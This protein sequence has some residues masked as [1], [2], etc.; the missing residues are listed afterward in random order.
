ME[1]EKTC[2]IGASFYVLYRGGDDS[3][4]RI[5]RLA[6]GE[7][8]MPPS[9]DRLCKRLLRAFF[10]D[11]L[12]LATPAVAKRLRLGKVTFLDK[13]LVEVD[14][15]EADLLALVGIR[16]GGLLLVHVEIE[17]RA[18]RKMPGRLRDYA[19]RIQT[20]YPGQLLSILVNLRGGAPGVQWAQGGGE[21]SAPEISS[22]RYVS[23][24]LAGCSAADYLT[25]PEPLA[26]ALA[27]L[28]VRHPM[29]RAEHKL[30]CLRRIATAE[31]GE[32]ARILLADFVEAYLELTVDEATEYKRLD[33]RERKEGRAVWM[34]WSEK[35]KAEGQREGKRE[36][37]RQLLLLQLDRRF[38][39]LP[40]RIRQKVE[41]ITSVQRLTRIAE[42]LVTAGSLRELG[43]R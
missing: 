33:I 12:R 24:G 32:D 37:M 28:M 39:P 15:R 41:T 36:G 35:L 40:E 43:I 27:A 8:T 31:L 3:A 6:S 4:A 19:H 7:T 26:W 16:G 10:P 30:A 21:L 11:L 17:A 34:T 38:G 14:R 2:Q 22:F 29:S 13:E 20:R 42:K 9:H 5:G 25:R 23:F 1:R 18:R